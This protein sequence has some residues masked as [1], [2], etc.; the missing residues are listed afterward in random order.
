MIGIRKIGIGFGVNKAPG[1]VV[2]NGGF[3]S[4]TIWTVGGL[5]TISGGTLNAAAASS[6]VFQDCLEIGATFKIIFSITDHTSGSV[7]VKSGTTVGTWRNG[8][9]TYEEDILCGGDTNIY[10]DAGTNFTAELDNVSAV[11]Q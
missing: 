5:W 11:K 2:K 3:D 10:I 8:V 1:N 7:R 9:G 4:D 6:S